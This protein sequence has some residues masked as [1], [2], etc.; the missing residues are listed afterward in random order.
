MT[1]STDR[2]GHAPIDAREATALLGPADAYVACV[3]D[4]VGARALALDA[5]LR[6]SRVEWSTEVN[7]AC[8]ECVDR[9]R[10][11]LNPVF[12]A[13]RCHTPERLATLL[14]HELAHVSM[15]HT[16]M[17]PRPTVA[18]NIACDAVINREI[19]ALAVQYDAHVERLTALLVDEYNAAEAPWFL[20]RPP[21]G[22]PAAPEWQA[23]TGMPRVLRSIHRR[24]Y[25]PLQLQ[26]RHAVQYSE[27]VDALQQACDARPAS[28]ARGKRLVLPEDCTR[29]LG[30]HGDTP[31]EERALTGGRDAVG[32]DVFDA[33]LTPIN[34]RLAGAGGP[35]MV[36]QVQRAQRRA[37]L[38]RALRALLVRCVDSG[39]ARRKVDWTTTPSRSALPMRDRRAPARVALANAFG[40]PRPLLFADETLY[41]RPLPQGVTVYLDTSGSMSN[42]LPVLHASLVPLRRQLKARML[43][44]STIV[45]ESTAADFDAGRLRT[46]GGTS[47]TPV[48]EHV[49]KE[50]RAAASGGRAGAR[51]VVLLTDGIFEAP[52]AALTTAM[53]THGIRVHLGVIGNGPSHEAEAWV[54]SSTALP[55]L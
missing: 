49:L 42:L 50:A 33:A 13:Q 28:G 31:V 32:G 11:L 4:I 25:D 24:L 38:E 15:G 1:P 23:S 46:T 47:V 7:T 2:Q 6:V 29:L 10:L 8:V 21:P 43:L 30:A 17:F 51:T 34:G 37:S 52:P 35:E 12:V 54:A 5:L 36:E 19:S 9:P 26:V 48:L 20:L 40:T 27:I 55:T 3:L 16:R 45:A 41:A 14:L 22:W 44:F 39:G 18:H 53:R